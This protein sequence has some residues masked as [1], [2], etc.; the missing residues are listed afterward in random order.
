[1]GES[2]LGTE[3]GREEEAKVRTIGGEKNSN[4]ASA[5]KP[6]ANPIQAK[7]LRKLHVH[8]PAR[9]ETSARVSQIGTDY[10]VLEGMNTG[11]GGVTL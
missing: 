1:L 3:E 10:F 9:C 4:V 5:R 2:V 7:N 8:T 11:T 6:A